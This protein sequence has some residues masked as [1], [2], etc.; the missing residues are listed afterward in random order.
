M[1]A[2]VAIGLYFRGYHR[3]GAHPEFLHGATAQALVDYVVLWAGSLFAPAMVSP[4]AV[5]RAALLLL[6]VCLVVAAVM[7]WKTGSWRRFYAPVLIAG[8]AALTAAVTAAGRIG[9]GVQQALDPRYRVFSLMLYLA[10]VAFA[11]AIYTALPTA[12]RAKRALVGA[13]CLLLAGLFVAGWRGA[14]RDVAANERS[15]HQRNFG[16]LRS[17]LWYEVV[18]HNP[19]LA[20]LHPVRDLLRDRIRVLRDC[21]VLRLP[22]VAPEIT[23]HLQPASA[24]NPARGRLEHC[25][26]ENERE[27]RVS[28][29]ARL[30]DDGQP[31]CVVIAYAE[32]GGW[33][34]IALVEMTWKPR[35]NERGTFSRT[36]PAA[37]LPA[38]NVTIAAWSADEKAGRLYPLDG[39]AVL[40]VPPPQQ[41]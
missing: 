15:L 40:D 11:A 24:D 33:R 28:G 2:A 26:L 36:L 12:A 29:S 41:P 39:T 34:P 14:V 17:L 21:G 7:A 8:Y 16:L 18:P 20:R 6:V 23:K 38:G 35:E 31:D 27:L 30:P 1:C 9:F 32:N 19:D 10:I 25:G 22:F 5:G 4:V 3:P 37:M 13:A